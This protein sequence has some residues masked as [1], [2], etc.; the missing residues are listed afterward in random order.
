[1]KQIT[2]E[3]NEVDINYDYY[4]LISTNNDNNIER[5]IFTLSKIHPSTLYYKDNQ[6]YQIIDNKIRCILPYNKIVMVNKKL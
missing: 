5:G 6:Y 4:E 3:F 1:M 2:L